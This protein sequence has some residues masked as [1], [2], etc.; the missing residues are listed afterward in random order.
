MKRIANQQEVQF[1]NSCQYVTLSLQLSGFGPHKGRL[2]HQTT[3]MANENNKGQWIQV[4]FGK[5]AKVTKIGTQGRYNVGQWVAKYTVSYSIDG[6]YFENQLHKP[7]NVPRVNWKFS[8]YPSGTSLILTRSKERVRSHERPG[9]RFSKASETCRASK[10]IFSHLYLK[11]R[12]VY[13]PET[14]YERNLSSY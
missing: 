4:D 10:A 3:Y 1:S 7:S 5:V 11:N 13:R 12:E 14:L 2:N 9:A 6:G 8:F